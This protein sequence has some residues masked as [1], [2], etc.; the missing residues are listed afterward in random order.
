M[1]STIG[2]Y[3]VD[4]NEPTKQKVQSLCTAMSLCSINK[5]SNAFD[6]LVWFIHVC[7]D[8][9][10]ALGRV[11]SLSCLKKLSSEGCYV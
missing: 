10:R 7:T 9:A 3:T 4:D 5:D 8:R 2:E 6:A 11:K 1:Q